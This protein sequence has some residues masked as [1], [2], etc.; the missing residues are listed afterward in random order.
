M[1]EAEKRW[2]PGIE[3]YMAPGMGLC[4]V[5]NDE[6]GTQRTAQ[7]LDP[8]EASEWLLAFLKGEKWV[9]TRTSNQDRS[10]GDA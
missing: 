5:Q 6:R 2:L 8:N 3:F 7:Y 4:G 10:Q 9:R 1:H